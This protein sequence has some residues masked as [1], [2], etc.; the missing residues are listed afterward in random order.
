MKNQKTP[1]KV[2]DNYFEQLTEKVIENMETQELGSS[3]RSFS[4][5]AKYVSAAAIL[6][7]VISFAVIQMQEEKT[8]V[9]DMDTISE[10]KDVKTTDDVYLTPY[11]D[12]SNQLLTQDAIENDIVDWSTSM[13][14]DDEEFY[15]L[16]N[17]F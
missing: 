16:I 7:F 9:A 8:I 17:Y 3:K 14:L 12:E 15:L 2:P 5:W 6:I 4:F 11:N 1:F 10:I 13:D